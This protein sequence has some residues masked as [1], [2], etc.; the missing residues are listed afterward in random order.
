MRVLGRC[1]WEETW[2]GTCRTDVDDSRCCWQ[3]LR[4]F[5]E[6]RMEFFCLQ[7]ESADMNTG[8]NAET[9]QDIRRQHIHTPNTS[10]LPIRRHFTLFLNDISRLGNTSNRVRD[11]LT[12]GSSPVEAYERAHAGV[13]DEGREV[14]VSRGMER[15]VQET[16][17]RSGQY[18]AVSRYFATENAAGSGSKTRM[19]DCDTDAFTTSCSDIAVVPHEYSRRFVSSRSRNM[20][21]RV[22]SIETFTWRSSRD[23][24]NNLHLAAYS[25]L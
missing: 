11:E 3:T 8:R 9:Y 16:G 12:S 25:S 13:Q 23:N 19:R 17:R 2:V 7:K 14:R 10:P 15:Q 1:R 21:T 5:L 4:R 6:M 24:K 22:H 18:K 20:C